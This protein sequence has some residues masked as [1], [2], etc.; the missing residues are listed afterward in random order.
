MGADWGGTPPLP[1]ATL[2]AG[3]GGTVG[4]TEPGS[5]AQFRCVVGDGSPNQVI[6]DPVCL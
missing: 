5:S 3:L 1:Q 6:K 4:G 2:S